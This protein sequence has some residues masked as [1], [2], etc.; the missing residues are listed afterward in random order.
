M[1]KTVKVNMRRVVWEERHVYYFGKYLFNKANKQICQAVGIETFVHRT[2]SRYRKHFP[3][4]WRKLPGIGWSFQV[5]SNFIKWERE[6]NKPPHQHNVNMW[7]RQTFAPSALPVLN[8]S[9]QST[10]N[11]LDNFQTNLL[12]QALTLDKAKSLFI[13]ECPKIRNKII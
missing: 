2:H 3:A 10:R 1:V 12:T 7:R 9:R 11:I 6:R 4:I 5:G 13:Q 8:H